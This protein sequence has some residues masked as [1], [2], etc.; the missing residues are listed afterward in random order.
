[1]TGISPGFKFKGVA[2]KQKPIVKRARKELADHLRQLRRLY[3]NAAASRSRWA[4][5]AQIEEMD[6]SL[7]KTRYMNQNLH[8]ES[9]DRHESK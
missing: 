5:K 6:R 8:H 4:E 2:W 9:G 1:M 3:G 7:F